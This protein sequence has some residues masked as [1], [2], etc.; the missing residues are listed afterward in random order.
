[1][2]TQ[3]R[4]LSLISPD[5]PH[6]YP[7][8][9]HKEP[10]ESLSDDLVLELVGLYFHY[11]HDRSH[12]LFHK[13]T[14]LESVRSKTCSTAVLCAICSIGLR[15]AE[16]AEK[17]S[18]MQALAEE[19]KTALHQNLERLCLANV[20]ACVLLAEI[21]ATDLQ[22]ETEALYFGV[23]NRM[24]HLLRLHKHDE[25]DSAILSETKKR[26]WWTL[27]MADLWCPAGLGL[28]RQLHDPAKY[29]DLPIEEAVFQ[30]LPLSEG[31]PERLSTKL[32]LWAYMIKLA[33]IFGSIQ[34]L[35]IGLVEHTLTVDDVDVQVGNLAQA[36]Q[37]YVEHLPAEVVWNEDNLELHRRGG[38]G[39]PFVALHLGHFFY[40]ILLYFQYLDPLRRG[41]TESVLH[42]QA[43]RSSA[44]AYSEVLRMS[45][46]KT[47]CDAIHN[48][49]GHMTVVASS[50]LLHILLF[51]DD[52]E[53]IAVARK[54]LHANFAALCELKNI[55]PMLDRKINRLLIFQNACLHTADHNTHKIDQWM[56][57]F[58]LEHAMPLDDKLAQAS[59]DP[60]LK[61]RHEFTSMALADVL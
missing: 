4:R 60:R 24:A 19:S 5:V 18:L 33:T 48:T 7:G 36:F 55:W 29:L 34:D 40:Q 20:Q 47:D 43:C 37:D 11:M 51:G 61:S 57:R 1:M 22:T 17:Q 25:T 31:P 32:G 26:V 38:F 27:V 39:G 14:L 46:S 58:L 54:Y 50:V 9:E 23:A 16:S 28:P 10:L 49:V 12:T 35:N 15:F 3:K 44:L 6:I 56:I 52:D 8:S 2:E 41:S 59:L 45:R 53:D 13:H 21:A 42:A 30:R